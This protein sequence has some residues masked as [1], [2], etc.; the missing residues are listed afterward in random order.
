MEAE[1]QCRIC[2]AGAS[3]E[4][5]DLISPCSCQ[6]SQKYVHL[7]CLR[8][9]QRSVQL[10]GSNRPS[11]SRRED[12][13]RVCNV[14]RTPFSVPPEDRASMMCRLA[15]TRSEDITPGLM[16][17]TKQS[18]AETTPHNVQLPLLL[19]V[20]V[21]AKA[22]HF[23]ESVYLLT[24]VGGERA[25]DGSDSVLG[26]NLTRA[27]EAPEDPSL[28]QDAVDS[29]TVRCYQGRGVRV[30]WMN[31]GPVSP[32][33]VRALCCLQRLPGDARA[34][35]CQR[36]GATELAAGE[37]SM[38]WGKLRSVLAVAAEEAAGSS[39]RA[40]AGAA[41]VL[42]WAGCARWSR[43]QL[44]GEMARG[45]WG[46]CQAAGADG[47]AAVAAVS[48][49]GRPAS[50]RSRGGLWAQL[51]PSERLHWAPDNELSRSVQLR[52]PSR[53]GPPREEDQRV[54]ALARLFEVQ[55]RAREGRPARH[56]AQQ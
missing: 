18:A 27:M 55:R 41:I 31:G 32:N 14:C 53:E 12:R 28:L 49:S 52:A 22:A 36:H 4:D 23:R 40:P 51:R 16:L 5:G 50:T 54:G 29:S 9:W 46:W 44:L 47:L 21:E 15:Q 33:T 30:R 17:V 1:P 19:R 8:H 20:Y 7:E 26:V 3:E 37:V 25:A 45:S 43:T 6:G 38:A 11:A 56:C 42:A 10:D 34:A 35:A 24:E 48:S 13:H 2:F 39:T